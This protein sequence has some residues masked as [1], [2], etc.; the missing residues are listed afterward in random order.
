MDDNT[1]KNVLK[2]VKFFIHPKKKKNHSKDIQSSLYSPRILSY[3]L[4]A[5]TS[6]LLTFLETNTVFSLTNFVSYAFTFILFYLA[7]F[8][9]QTLKVL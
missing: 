3:M 1:T 5:L 2:V 8:G 6:L 7:I 4:G 9:Q